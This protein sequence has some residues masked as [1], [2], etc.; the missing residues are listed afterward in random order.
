MKNE[1]QKMNNSD[2][3][4]APLLDQILYDETGMLVENHPSIAEAME[5]YHQAKLNVIWNDCP[6][7]GCV[8]KICLALNSDKC[9]PHTKGNRQWKLLK[10]WWKHLKY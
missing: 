3:E 1:T 4:K 5:K 9:F 7:E 2:F 10:I 8:N 6:I